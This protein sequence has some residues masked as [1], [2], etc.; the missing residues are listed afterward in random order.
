MRRI[1]LLPLSETIRECSYTRN[2]EFKLYRMRP[3]EMIQFNP[4]VL[5]F[6]L[7]NSIK[8]LTSMKDII[9]LN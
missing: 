7:T 2:H 9:C 6:T 4:D 1:F 8:L 3:E 5:V